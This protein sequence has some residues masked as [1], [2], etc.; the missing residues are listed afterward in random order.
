MDIE[1]ISMGTNIN[2]ASLLGI[3]LG[4]KLFGGANSP[5]INEA[6]CSSTRLERKNNSRRERISLTV[7]HEAGLKTQ[8]P[9]Y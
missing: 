9:L 1:L 3:Q 8:L 2:L 7:L 4:T 6:A 5:S